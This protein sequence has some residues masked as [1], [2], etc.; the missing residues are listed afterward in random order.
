MKQLD[1]SCLQISGGGGGGGSGHETLHA[2]Q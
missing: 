1:A 2:L